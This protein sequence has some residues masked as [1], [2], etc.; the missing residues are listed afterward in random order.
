MH[1]FQVD[2]PEAALDDLRLRLDHIRWP[3]GLPEAGWTRG[4]PIDYLREL[5]DYWRHSYDWRKAEAELNQVP[6]FTTTIDGATVYFIHVR[7]SEESAVPL[8]ITHGWPGSV[9]EFLEVIGPLTD[10]RAYGGNPA[11][12]FHLV[13]PSIPGFGFSGPIGEGGWDASRVGRAWAEL[14]RQL[15]YDRYL[16]QAADFGIGINLALAAMDSEHLIGLHLN[17]VPTMPATDDPAELAGLDADEQ[18]R[19][20]H[21]DRFLREF[22]GSMKIQSTRP[23]T[24]AYGLNDSPVAQLAWIVEKFKDWTDSDQA[25]EDAVTRDRILT[26]VMSY[27]LTQ[28]G[29][30]SA[31]FYFEIA[32]YLPVNV[33]TGR[34]DPISMPLGIAVYPHAPFIPVRRFLERDFPTLVQWNEF[35]RGGNFAALEEPDL[36]IGDI[37]AFRRTVESAT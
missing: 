31:Q 6:Q 35:D 36:Y 5:T 2:V 18:R 27:W 23:H 15:G 21:R 19:M 24:V 30:S 25:P 7:S 1:P 26:I 22:S 20:A 11:D 16:A 17:G 28:T 3:V 33:T 29:G 9:V 10:P 12:A 13:I 4:V 37:R 32:D 34:Y 8:L 14:M